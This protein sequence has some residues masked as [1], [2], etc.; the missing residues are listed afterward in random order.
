MFKIYLSLTK[1][2]IIFGNIIT[3]IGGFFLASKGQIDIVLL[4][5]MIVGL[6]LIIASACVFNNIIDRDIDVKMARTKNR[7]LVTH[8][9]FTRN[10]ILYAIVLGMVGIFILLFLTNLLT[11]CISLI[12]FFF[13]VVVYG[14]GKRR[15][16]YG[17]VIGSISGAVPPVVGYC[18]VSNQFDLGA[19]L[20]FVILVL[21]QMPHFYAIAIFRSTDYA[22]ASIPVLP[23]K[24]GMHETK[25]Q[26]IVYIIAFIIATM[27][28]TVFGITG[29]A[30]LIIALLLGLWWLFVGVKGFST[31]DDKKWARKM[32]RTSLIVL[33]L[34]CVMLS[35]DVF[36]QF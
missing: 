13:Y 31:T 24:K 10:A 8:R 7:A 30:Y 1:P 11:L 14:I 17:T 20:L 6:S 25:I 3:A 15:T 33:T 36:F 27:L 16:V 21:W 4:L 12:G 19:L 35:V 22:A 2:G 29:S 9:V 28:L 18:A 5:A 23:L 34:L 26:M 32:F